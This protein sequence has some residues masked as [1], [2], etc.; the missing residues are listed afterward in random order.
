[1]LPIHIKFVL[2]AWLILISLHASAATICEGMQISEV[3]S[4]YRGRFYTE[5][6]FAENF[7]GWVNWIQYV[8]GADGR[9]ITT[10]EAQFKFLQILDTPS[11]NPF[12][13]SMRQANE[14]RIFDRTYGT[15]PESQKFK[16]DFKDGL[17]SLEQRLANIGIKF[18]PEKWERFVNS[19]NTTT[20]EFMAI[21]AGLTNGDYHVVDSMARAFRRIVKEG[22][23][24]LDGVYRI[25][26]R[27]G[28]PFWEPPFDTVN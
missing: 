19:L 8:S 10:G 2:T 4:K 23:Y 22:Q 6:D 27:N 14:G 3:V 25:Q 7:N 26:E 18:N 28:E 20:R 16:K 9:S 5:M 11:D 12:R 21:Q 24:D 13:P 15:S 17:A 1:M